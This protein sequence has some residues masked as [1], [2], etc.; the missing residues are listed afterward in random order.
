MGKISKKQKRKQK[1]TVYISLEGYREKAFYDFLY[2]IHKPKENGI[3]LNIGKNRGGSSDVILLDAIK[4]KNNCEEVYAW[5]DEDV[6][7]T[8]DTKRILA[9]HWNV[10]VEQI[11]DFL[12]TEDRELQKK[13]NSDKK[14]KPILIVSNPIS[15]EGLLIRILGKKSLDLD[16]ITLKEKKGRLKSAFSGIIDCRGQDSEK[17]L[18]C[19]RKNLNKKTLE[20]KRLEIYE[21]D[22][23]LSI[24]EK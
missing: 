6:V 23:I 14:Q 16:N 11:E 1:K 12:T 22:L 21:L 24:F 19:Y 3:N 2:E 20:E 18:K 8:N 13:Y 15:L 7:I 17:E 4:K 5:F 9:E 10:P